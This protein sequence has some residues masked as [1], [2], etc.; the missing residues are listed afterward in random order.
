M[1]FQYPAG[2]D[3]DEI[4]EMVENQPRLQ[5]FVYC[6][7]TGKEYKL[8]NLKSMDNTNK[9]LAF[10]ILDDIYPNNIFGDLERFK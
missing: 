6:L 7:Y 8:S 4:I 2:R 5:E 10:Q 9:G 3:I 1:S